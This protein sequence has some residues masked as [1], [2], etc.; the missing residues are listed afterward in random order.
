MEC[1]ILQGNMSRKSWTNQCWDKI[2][3][4][5]AWLNHDSRWLQR[6]IIQQ[7]INI[8]AQDTTE[9]K[10]KSPA[11]WSTERPLF[12]IY[13]PSLSRQDPSLP[14]SASGNACGTRSSASNLYFQVLKDSAAG[15][16]N[17]PYQLALC[18]VHNEHLINEYGIMG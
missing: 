13:I 10:K 16:G 5:D 4:I 18:L 17:P 14:S 1:A 3:K 7:Q 8:Q 2:G 15:L 11:S 6:L 9:N 12:G